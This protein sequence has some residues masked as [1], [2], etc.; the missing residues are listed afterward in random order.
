[1]LMVVLLALLAI[2]CLDIIRLPMTCT[3]RCVADAHVRHE[4]SPV[5]VSMPGPVLY[6]SVQTVAVQ[7][8]VPCWY[9]PMRSS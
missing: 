3:K 7:K 1:M 8:L 4:L 9:C 6:H 2:L 5:L